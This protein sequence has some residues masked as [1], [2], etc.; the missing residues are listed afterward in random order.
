M[1]NER[2]P[3]LRRRVADCWLPFLGSGWESDIFLDCRF[4]TFLG[5]E[6]LGLLLGLTVFRD[7]PQLQRATPLEWISSSG[8]DH[9]TA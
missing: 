2:D 9:D 6:D 1:A 8:S 5:T 3:T 7:C 4:F